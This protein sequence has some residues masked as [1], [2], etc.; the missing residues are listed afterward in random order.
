[1]APEALGI[2]CAP[3]TSKAGAPFA[4]AKFCAR[5]QQLADYL[6]ARGVRFIVVTCP[7]KN[8][9]YPEH[10]RTAVPHRPADTVYQKYARFLSQ[11]S[12]RFS[13]RMV[14]VSLG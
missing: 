12:K 11:L 1:M 9:V 6:E 14:A 3:N 2:C 4:L 8:T 13:R 7:M 10:F 5:T